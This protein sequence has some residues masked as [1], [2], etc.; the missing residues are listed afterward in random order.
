MSVREQLQSDLKDAMRSSDSIRKT[1][2]RG[3]MT[4]IKEAEQ[5]NRESLAKKALSE[6]N[7]VKPRSQ[8]DSDA[9]RAYQEAVDRALA[10]ED[11]EAH[12]VL[13]ESAILALIQ[14]IARQRQEGVEQANKAGR[15]DI[16]VTEAAEL[17][18]LEAYLPQQMTRE[19]VEEVARAVIAEMNATELRDM[20]RVMSPLME[21]LR[22]QADG[23]MVSDVV[24]SLLAG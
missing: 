2:I 4:A 3:V 6:H 21:K 7:V 10:A 12:S 19:E 15:D 9:L 22:G 16:A 20:G 23:K 14:K 18:L 24:R 8:D 1:V 11:V 5:K 17:A 13:D